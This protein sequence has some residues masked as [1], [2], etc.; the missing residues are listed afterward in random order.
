M[1]RATYMSIIIAIVCVFGR[2]ILHLLVILVGEINLGV[3]VH[4]FVAVRPVILA[5]RIANR[6]GG[7]VRI[8][9]TSRTVVARMKIPA[10]AR[11]RILI[12]IRTDAAAT[13]R[14]IGEIIRTCTIAAT[15]AVLDYVINVT[16]VLLF[17]NRRHRVSARLGIVYLMIGIVKLL[18]I[19]L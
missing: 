15:I 3:V 13:I 5:L 18:I 1:M 11:I 6:I 4:I 12:S 9:G 17:N 7:L 8:S 16:D 19:R 2:I 10:I 14:I